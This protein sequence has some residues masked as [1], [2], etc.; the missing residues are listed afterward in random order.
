MAE[1]PDVN[2]AAAGAHIGDRQLPE[3]NKWAEAEPTASFLAPGEPK[4]DALQRYERDASAIVEA[5]TKENAGAL[6]PSAA[7]LPASGS[8]TFPV[9]HMQVQAGARR[10]L[11]NEQAGESGAST[12]V[13]GPDAPTA[14]PRTDGAAAEAL[15]AATAPGDVPDVA[16]FVSTIKLV[17]SVTLAYG[18]AVDGW[19]DINQCM[20]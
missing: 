13:P 4:S 16:Q 7:G 15:W 5:S 20:Y 14:D 10:S 11:A 17:A 19:T 3:A 8:R 6:R 2:G 18:N 12:N 1:D 9:Q